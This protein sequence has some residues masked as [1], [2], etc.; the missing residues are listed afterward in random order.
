MIVLVIY[1]YYLVTT[2]PKYIGI[3][4][5][6]KSFY[7]NGFIFQVFCYISS[8]LLENAYFHS[9]QPSVNTTINYRKSQ[10]PL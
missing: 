5:T 8:V 10:L 9:F 3:G 1:D 2:F 7:N 6:K 4:T